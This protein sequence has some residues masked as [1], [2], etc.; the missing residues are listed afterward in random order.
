MPRSIPRAS[1]CPH[2]WNGEFRRPR[3]LFPDRR[4]NPVSTTTEPQPVVDLRGVRHVYRSAGDVELEAISGADL[5]VAPGEFVALIGPSGCGKTTLLNII[6]GLIRPTEGTVHVHG[7]APASGTVD[8]GMVFQTPVLFPWRTIA[9]NVALPLELRRIPKTERHRRVEELLDLVGLT[10]F[11]ARLPR[12]LSGGMQQRAAIARALAAD[13][14]LL[15]M[16][17][18][19]GAVD[20]ITRERMNFELKQISTKAGKAVVLVTHSIEEA[21]FLADRIVVM[22]ARPA[23]IADVIAVGL[24]DSLG[25]D[26]L[27]TA[28]FAKA[29]QEVRR[30][31][32]V[33]DADRSDAAEGQM[34]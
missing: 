19:F 8:V 20:S 29:S 6:A 13:A 28:E 32:N 25:L 27:G 12:E 15:L 26:L 14:P 1:E 4:D 22:S 2:H 17:E 21:V 16:D 30:A 23:R 24:E 11:G 3:G 5:R 10:G 18:P 33:H 9:D 7:R 34:R 31:L